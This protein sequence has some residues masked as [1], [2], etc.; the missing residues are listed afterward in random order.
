MSLSQACKYLYNDQV[1]IGMS[2]RT[3][4]LWELLSL[5]LSLFIKFPSHTLRF[6]LCWGWG[7]S[8]CSSH[9]LTHIAEHGK[10]CQIL[11][12]PSHGVH[13][14]CFKNSLYEL[15]FSNCFPT[16]TEIENWTAFQLLSHSNWL[17]IQFFRIRN[18]S[19]FS[20]LASCWLCGFHLNIAAWFVVDSVLR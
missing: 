2:A 9:Y 15:L 19:L 4:Y 17:P 1:L 20:S 5:W 18:I 16:Y 6:W 11:I 8:G 14:D 10:G 7:I 3:L 13:I 12:C